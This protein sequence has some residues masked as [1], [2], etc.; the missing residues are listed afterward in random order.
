MDKREQYTF[1]ALGVLVILVLI[2]KAK[3]HPSMDVPN[4]LGSV[5]DA[6]GGGNPQ[7]QFDAPYTQETTPGIS[8]SQIIL[9]GGAPFQST[10]N[11]Q[12][13][14]SAAM[15][16][17]EQY[18][19]LF[20]FVGMGF[21][22]TPTAPTQQLRAPPPSPVYFAPSPAPAPFVAAPYSQPSPYRGFSGSGGSG[23]Q[24]AGNPYIPH[25]G[26]G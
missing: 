9:N 26:G 17:S 21:A 5:D 2:L 22:T 25:L 1:A 3:G 14:V 20:G 8:D 13:N 12:I 23:P 19:P 7:A 15:Q 11:Q 16:L 10:I 24:I 18:I 4:S 6:E